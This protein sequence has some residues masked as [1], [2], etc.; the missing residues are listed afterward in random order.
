MVFNEVYLTYII[1]LVYIVLLFSCSTITLEE[2]LVSLKRVL[3]S[4]GIWYLY[5]LQNDHHNIGI[6]MY[7]K[8]I[9]TVSLIN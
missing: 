5:V 2:R 6:C 4:V 1:I 7:C 8:M 3:T 9:T